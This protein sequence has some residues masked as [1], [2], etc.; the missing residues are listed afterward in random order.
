[1]SDKLKQTIRIKRAKVETDDRGRTVWSGPVEEA[2]LE[3]V[4]TAMLQ[5]I[6]ADDEGAN[7]E[8]LNAVAQDK[9]GVLARNV[10]T[11][12]YEIIDDY[13]LQGAD[14]LSL[15]STQALRRIL[16]K[17]TN[18]AAGETSGNDDSDDDDPGSGG[19]DPYNSA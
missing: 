6:I 17:D 19:F 14:E 13:E 3:L 7:R 9:D 5:K 15:V 10:D 1:M 18:P 12:Q 4:S 11:D 16:R 2:E 8:R